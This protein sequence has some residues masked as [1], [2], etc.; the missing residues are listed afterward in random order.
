M[1]VGYPPYHSPLPMTDHIVTVMPQSQDELKV[2]VNAAHAASV[3][4]FLEN[5]GVIVSAKAA[6]PVVVATV[7][8]GGSGAGERSEKQLVLA[9]EFTALTDFERLSELIDG[10]IGQR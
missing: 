4:G 3:M 8:M 2:L 9:Y 10:W 1:G 7:S 6:D 5:N